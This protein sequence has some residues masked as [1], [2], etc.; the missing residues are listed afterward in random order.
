MT[1]AE[2]KWRKIDAGPRHVLYQL[3]RTPFHAWV[4]VAR[5]EDLPDS[6]TA[7]RPP[8]PFHPEAA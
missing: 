7:M 3:G 2:T 4:P 1:T 5:M 8:M 6:G